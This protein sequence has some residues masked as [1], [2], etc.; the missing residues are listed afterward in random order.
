MKI[1][2]DRQSGN[3]YKLLLVTSFLEIPYE[4][5]DIDIKK[6]KPKQIHF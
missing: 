6:E 1:Y 3:S 4:W 2:G 5:Q